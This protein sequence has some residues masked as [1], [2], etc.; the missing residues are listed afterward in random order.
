MLIFEYS[1]HS[2]G[3]VARTPHFWTLASQGPSAG[4]QVAHFLTT[5]RTDL[6]PSCRSARAILGPCL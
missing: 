5:H 4:D 1:R 2:V 6:L 3:S